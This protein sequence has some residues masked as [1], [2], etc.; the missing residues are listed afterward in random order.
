MLELRLFL[1]DAFNA[2]L[3]AILLFA[4]SSCRLEK[5]RAVLVGKVVRVRHGD[6]VVVLAGTDTA[7]VLCLASGSET[8]ASE[9]VL[10]SSAVAGQADRQ[11]GSRSQTDTKLAA[12]QFFRHARCCSGQTMNDDSGGKG[13]SHCSRCEPSRK[14]SLQPLLLL[15]WLR[16]SCFCSTLPV[17]CLSVCTRTTTTATTAQTLRFCATRLRFSGRLLRLLEAQWTSEFAHCRE[18]GGKKV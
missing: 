9:A 18:F 11:L 14:P 2:E 8:V 6:A 16:L 15:L 13:K 3:F 10:N 12:R 1:V 4:A 17:S 5:G 7:P